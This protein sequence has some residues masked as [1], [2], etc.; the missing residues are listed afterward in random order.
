MTIKERYNEVLNTWSDIQKH[1]P[2]LK[3]YAG[4]CDHITELGTD[5]GTS[6]WAFL[7]GKPKV[8]HCYDI[9]PCPIED[10]IQLAKDENIEFYEAKAMKA[11]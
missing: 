7:A 3:E 5:D 6:T 11:E 4:K 2:L 9:L 10:L 1:M 8:I